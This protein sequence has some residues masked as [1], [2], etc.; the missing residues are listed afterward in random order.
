M[1]II[2]KNRA[3][4]Y[5]FRSV[6]L[7]FWFLYWY[8]WTLI[9]SENYNEI[10]IKSYSILALT[11]IITR[12]IDQIFNRSLPSYEFLFHTISIATYIISLF[13]FIIYPSL[14]ELLYVKML[15][16]V[17]LIYVSRKMMTVE[18]NELG[19]VGIFTGVLI[20]TLTYF[21]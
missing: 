15:F 5:Y 13:S 11:Y 6:T 12:F 2:G 21:Y 10:L 18:L 1:K 16:S 7:L 19:L 8:K 17:L 3:L 9:T 4:E 14:I 20:L